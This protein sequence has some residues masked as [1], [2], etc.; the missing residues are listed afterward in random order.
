M[1]NEKLSIVKTVFSQNIYVQKYPVIRYLLVS[2]PLT[3]IK[4]SVLWVGVTESS[5]FRL[6]RKFSKGFNN[7]R[8]LWTP[9]SIIYR[10]KHQLV[11]W[12]RC[13]QRHGRKGINYTR[14]NNLPS[15]HVN[16]NN[17]SSDLASETKQVRFTKLIL[18]HINI[19]YTSLS[20]ILDFYWEMQTFTKCWEL[21]VVSC[22]YF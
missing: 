20:M 21:N 13:T 15:V 8:W 1:Y 5:K 10:P 9:S 7:D 19:Q 2:W 22:Y 4:F 18:R 3:S 11:G 17:I 14:L 16:N 6:V 12:T